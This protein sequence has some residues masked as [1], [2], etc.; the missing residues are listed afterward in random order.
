MDWTSCINVSLCAKLFFGISP[1]EV[2]IPMKQH[3]GTPCDPVVS[4]GDEVAMGDLIGVP[5]DMNGVPVHASISGTVTKIDMIRLPNKV[6]CKSCHD[7]E[8]P[9][10]ACFLQDPAEKRPLETVI[11]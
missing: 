8:R 11:V 5:S 10:P 6:S 3:I 1:E 7:Q 9:A 2:T 4:V